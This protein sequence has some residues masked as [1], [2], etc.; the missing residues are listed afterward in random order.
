MWGCMIMAVLWAERNRRILKIIQEHALRSYEAEFV[1]G[2]HYGH[3]FSL[4]WEFLS[5]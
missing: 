5:P 3:L 1:F 4:S 2:L